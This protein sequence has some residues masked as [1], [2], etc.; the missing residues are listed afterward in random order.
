MGPETPLQVQSSIARC[1]LYLAM[2]GRFK[3]AGGLAQ[4]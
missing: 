3:P 1:V 4:Q 2:D